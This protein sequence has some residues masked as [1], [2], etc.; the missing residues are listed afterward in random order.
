MV[1]AV[2]PVLCHAAHFVERG[3]DIT[4]QHLSSEGTVEAF[5]VGVL[6]WL[7]WLD[8]DQLNTVLLC[9]LA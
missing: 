1:V 8:M 5:D 9:P 7:S 4:I 6:C 3:E 2:S